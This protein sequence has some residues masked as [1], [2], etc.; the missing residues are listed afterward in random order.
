MKRQSNLSMQPPASFPGRI[1]QTANSPTDSGGDPFRPQPAQD[2][3]QDTQSSLGN[4]S[5]VVV[6]TPQHSVVPKEMPG[7]S[8]TL[9]QQQPNQQAHPTPEAWSVTSAEIREESKGGSSKPPGG[10]LL[11][12][13]EQQRQK[14]QELKRG[15]NQV[16]GQSS[17]GPL[18]Q[19]KGSTYFQSPAAE[20]DS[21]EI[22]QQPSTQ[23]FATQQQDSLTRRNNSKSNGSFTNLAVTGDQTSFSKR[24]SP[25]ARHGRYASTNETGLNAANRPGSAA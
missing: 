22:E 20:I 2:E 8:H 1:D 3:M 13:I 23:R 12:G 6:Q 7:T 19:T 5:S 10:G 9:H 16:S 24:E 11:S 15:L 17:R 4:F 18:S 21:K 25:M 14:L